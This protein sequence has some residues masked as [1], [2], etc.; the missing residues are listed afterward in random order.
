MRRNHCY[1]SP[2][3]SSFRPPA[4]TSPASVFTLRW[5]AYCPR[6]RFGLVFICRLP[7]L[8]R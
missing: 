8:G 3:V 2:P 6:L 5:L 7:Y 4:S 1:F